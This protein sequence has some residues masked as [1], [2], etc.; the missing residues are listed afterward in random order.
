[1]R[2][3]RILLFLLLVAALAGVYTISQNGSNLPW[4]QGGTPAGPS[5][6]EQ[7]A[8]AGDS[9]RPT[10]DVVRA[11]PTGEVVMAG[12]AEP[13]WTTTVE[14][15][16]KTVGSAVADA[17]GEWVIEPP[18][19]IARGEH[20][21]RLKAQS[22][23]TGQTVFSKQRLALSLGD[24]GK[25]RPLVALTEEG[26]GTRVLQM[27][28]P[29]SDEKKLGA[30]SSGAT[31]NLQTPPFKPRAGD[32]SPAQVS[33]S[34]IDYDQATGRSTLYLSGK[35]T[36]GARLL[37]YADNDFI[38]TAM[39]DATGS[40]TFKASRELASGVH[41]MRADSVEL[42]G[43]KVLARAEVTFERQGTKAVASADDS[44][45]GDQ[46]ALASGSSVKTKPSA[47]E[48]RQA[49][50]AQPRSS[51]AAGGGVKTAS[52]GDAAAVQVADNSAD[53]HKVIVVRRGDTLWQIAERRFGNGAKYT[54]IFRNNR[55]QIRNP[56]LIYPDQRFSMPQH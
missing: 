41:A 20:S 47:D 11:E 38:G 45:A 21:L 33:F 14:S 31:A 46:V 32:E 35:G 5:S 18:S 27:S 15:N 13:G 12:R 19:A 16:G 44:A 2:R 25:D 30:I 7:Q 36:P 50:P 26:E 51:T 54:Q 9:A 3:S 17:N 42:A 22:P 28:P 4:M 39:V 23:R 55:G 29:L 56:D 34:A 6:G 24:P 52:D 48:A 8:N 53:D 43:G 10:F 37:L 1:M 49:E 40:W